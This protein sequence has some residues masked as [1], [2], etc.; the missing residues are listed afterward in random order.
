MLSFSLFMTTA[1]SSFIWDKV[2]YL[3]YMQFPWRFLTFATIFISIVGGYS[4]FFLSRLLDQYSKPPGLD[5]LFG[6]ARNIILTVFIIFLT[7]FI[8]QKYFRPERLIT[9]TD[10]QRTSNEEVKWRI[11]G[12]SYEFV[13]K[14]VAIK[15]SSLGTTQLAIEKQDV[16]D[17]S[18]TTVKGGGLVRKL[19]D[20]F[21]NKE[22]YIRTEKPL[23]FQLNTYHFPGW[24]A[25]LNE[26]KIQINDKNKLHL[27]TVSIPAGKYKLDFIFEDT[28]IRKLANILTFLGF[29]GCVVILAFQF[30]KINS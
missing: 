11:S 30:K 2:K 6:R 4:V 12:T 1:Y 19:Q 21:Q 24:S 22:F 28:P 15:K 25:Y 26:N 13:P 10:R 14:E 18:F 17:R 16:P 5:I 9:T 20:K 8:Y 23:L 29:L 3:W 27:M 7:I